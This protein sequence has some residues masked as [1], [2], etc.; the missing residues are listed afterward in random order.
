M[1]L[2]ELFLNAFDDRA[3]IQRRLPDLHPQ[4]L[5]F[6]PLEDVELGLA[7]TTCSFTESSDVI[8]QH[9]VLQSHLPIGLHIRHSGNEVAF[10]LRPATLSLRRCTRTSRASDGVAGTVAEDVSDIIWIKAA[11]GLVVFWHGGLL[12]I[13]K[14]IAVQLVTGANLLAIEF[15]GGEEEIGGDVRA[16]LDFLGDVGAEFSAIVFPFFGLF[17]ALLGLDALLGGFD[18]FGVASGD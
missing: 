15:S 6:P 12:G 4:L 18:V 11:A 3:L 8:L 14:L 13:G 10:A 1:D 7:A 2:G 17:A 9:P 16:L 5:P